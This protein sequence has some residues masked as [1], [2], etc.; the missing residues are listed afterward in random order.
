MH[1]I[2]S[3]NPPDIFK[4]LFTPLNQIHS[5]ATRSAT[6]GAFFWQAASNKYGKRSLKHLGPKIWEYIDPSLYELSSFTF[7]KRYRDNL[8]A[9]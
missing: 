9:A 4:Q 3:C 2:H 6:Q 8:I 5:Y 1:K 7:K